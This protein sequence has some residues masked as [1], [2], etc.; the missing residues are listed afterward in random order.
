MHVCVC[1]CAYARAR[2]VVDFQF[3]SVLISEA[4]RG[5]C[6]PPRC[7]KIEVRIDG[8]LMS[9]PIDRTGTTAVPA[10]P[11][12]LENP[13]VGSAESCVAQRVAH[14][15]HSTVNVTKIIN[16]VPQHLRYVPRASGEGLEE[17]QDV[18]RGPR[19]NECQQD[20]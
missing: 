13:H 15:V 20:G 1:V 11:L 8:L 12:T 5:D 18:V 3:C 7:E 6:S 16:K 10:L 19:D 4:W 17:Y 2:V 9:S 14:R